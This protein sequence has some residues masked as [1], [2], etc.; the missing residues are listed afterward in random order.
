MLRILVQISGTRFL[1]ISPSIKPDQPSKKHSSSLSQDK[2]L[3][4]NV[5]ATEHVQ[6][7]FTKHLPGLNTYTYS[8]K[9]HC[10]GTP[11]LELH[12]LHSD[13]IWCYKITFGYIN[14]TTTE[15]LISSTTRVT[16]MTARS[17]FFTERVVNIW[18]SSPVDTDFSSLT[19]SI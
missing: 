10:L 6:R 11:T 1:S 8:E 9:L 3:K 2:Y 18:N 4:C 17:S 12:C 16:H 5:E 7:R 14:V 13:L 15:F 19:G